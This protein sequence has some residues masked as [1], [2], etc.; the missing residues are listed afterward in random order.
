MICLNG[1]CDTKETNPV[2]EW[3]IS[4]GVQFGLGLFE[5][6]RLVHGQI[7]DLSKHLERMHRSAIEMGIV[8][9]KIFQDL[10]ALS[11]QLAPMLEAAEQPLSVLK[12]TLIKTGDTSSWWAQTRAFPY[13]KTQLKTGLKV[14]VSSVRRNSTS[15]LQRYKSLNYAE[16]WLEKKKSV[17]NGYQEV[18][19]LN[20]DSF[21]A[22][23]S[24]TN[25]FFLKDGIWH[26]PAIEIGLLNGI[27]RQR[28]INN[29]ASSN[30]ELIEGAFTYQQLL[31]ADAVVLTNALMGV[32]P[33]RQIGQTEFAFSEAF[34]LNDLEK[35]DPVRSLFI[36]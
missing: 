1:R 29:M 7:E 33:V 16:N 27:M 20:E 25:I 14:S 19:F 32:M 15:L 24:A 8:F 10:D 3:L 4:E 30:A 22:E 17:E 2:E 26:T 18:I 13:S 11:N 23:G 6:M 31:S 35:I 21:V 36:E 34:E 5:T 12:L 9:P 28:V